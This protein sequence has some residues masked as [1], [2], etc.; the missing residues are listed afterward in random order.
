VVD[1]AMR[2]LTRL[3]SGWFLLLVVVAVAGWAIHRRARALAGV[4]VAV[5]VAAEGLNVLLKLLLH[6]ARPDLWELVVPNSYSFPSGHAMVSTAVYGMA[7]FVAARL[8]PRLRWPLYIGMP[9]V[10]LVIGISRV[11]L[12]VHWATDVLAGF[13]AGGLLLLAGRLA[14]GHPRLRTSVSAAGSHRPRRLP[15]EARLES[16]RARR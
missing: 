16:E 11:Y 10:V 12:G 5:A 1:D 15:S 7:A 6:R 4:L 3:G 8:W 13:A 9:L 2:A 14:L